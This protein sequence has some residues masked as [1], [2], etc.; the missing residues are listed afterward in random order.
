MKMK[1]SKVTLVNFAD[2]KF[3]RKQKLN[4]FTAKLLGGFHRV[5]EFSPKDVDQELFRINKES[6]KYIEKGFGNYF[7]KPIIVNK[8]IQEIED[9]S[10]LM[11][12]DSGSLFAKKISPLLRRM[13]E[14]NK[15]ILCFQLPLIE[16]QWT[17]RDAFLLMDCDKPFYADSSQNLATF[18]IV[19][20]C[21][22]SISFLK[23]WMN[24]CSDSRILSDDKNVLGEGNYSEF[25]EHRHDQSVLSLLSKKYSDRVLLQGDISDY[26]YYPHRYYRNTSRLF[27]EEIEYPHKGI[28]ISTRTAGTIPYLCKYCIRRVLLFMDIKI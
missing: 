10:F 11:Y 27:N 2:E 22:E 6:A 21:Q 16:K 24:Y 20:K 1:N 25:I 14:K 23:E 3:R 8:A 4:S 5:L 19:R 26:G 15:N 7:W 13:D 18:F 9:G 12:A 17:K 28:L